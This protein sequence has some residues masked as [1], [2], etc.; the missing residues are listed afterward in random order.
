MHIYKDTRLLLMYAEGILLPNLVRV[1]DVYM[2]VCAL[3]ASPLACNLQKTQ[4][5]PPRPNQDSV[6]DACLTSPIS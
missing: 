3:A 4:R 1:N 2:Y 5:T 6:E